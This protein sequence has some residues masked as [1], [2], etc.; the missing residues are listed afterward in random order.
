[1]FLCFPATL[2]K[3]FFNIL[4]CFYC[5]ALTSHLIFVSPNYPHQNVDDLLG[6]GEAEGEE[7]EEGS[8]AQSIRSASPVAL[9]GPSPTPDLVHTDGT[10]ILFP[11][12]SC[13]RTGYV[14]FGLKKIS[15]FLCIHHQ[16]NYNKDALI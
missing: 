6:G 13:S 16:Q 9:I 8:V 7:E 3:I 15:I 11:G 14:C 4:F 10:L 1:M 5:F 12:N 2:E